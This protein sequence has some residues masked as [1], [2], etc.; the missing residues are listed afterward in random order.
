[1]DSVLYTVLETFSIGLV[2]VSV[3]ACALCSVVI[4]FRKRRARA[5]Q[6]YFHLCWSGVTEGTYVFRFWGS[7]V[8]VKHIPLRNDEVLSVSRNPLCIVQNRSVVVAGSVW[9]P[10]LRKCGEAVGREMLQYSESPEEFTST[11]SGGVPRP[12]HTVP[13][14]LQHIRD[15][16]AASS[17][18]CAFDNGLNQDGVT[19]SNVEDRHLLEMIGG[20]GFPMQQALRPLNFTAPRMHRLRQHAAEAV[21]NARSA[22]APATLPGPQA[23]I[24]V[25]VVSDGSI[26]RGQRVYLSADGTLSTRPSGTSVGRV[27][28]QIH[29]N[30]TEVL[31]TSE[32]GLRP[33]R[34]PGVSTWD[35]W[36]NTAQFN[37]GMVRTEAEEAPLEEVQ[38]GPKSRIFF[39]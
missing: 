11:G 16:W 21:A 33:V 5:W 31:M 8:R 3:S 1:M 39:E 35:P 19:L 24:S 28:S 7:E 38:E 26:V 10:S 14:M 13:E 15:H 6:R 9:W 32:S 23:V 25:P 20:G 30:R 37:A 29:P 4:Q 18:L 2:V 22:R 36:G 34:S 12:G 27:M 17:W